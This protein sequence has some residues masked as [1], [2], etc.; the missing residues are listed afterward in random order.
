MVIVNVF[1]LILIDVYICCYFFI[2]ILCYFDFYVLGLGLFILFMLMLLFSGVLKKLFLIGVFSCFLLVINYE[3]NW[4]D[5][6]WRLNILVC[7]LMVSV[8]LLI[9]V[10]N[11]MIVDVF[12]LFVLVGV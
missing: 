3:I 4:F 10:V 5:L 9:F 6:R 8:C 7:V 11:G 1:L 2:F 12:L